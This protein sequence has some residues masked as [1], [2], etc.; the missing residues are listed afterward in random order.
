[1]TTPSTIAFQL[2]VDATWTTYAAFHDDGWTMQI[3]PD[4][5][6]GWRPNKLST[7]FQ[8]LD[9]SMDPSNVTS[10]LYGKI[11]Q[12]TPARMLIN[13]N[14]VV[15]VEASDWQPDRT[16]DHTVTPAKGKAWVDLT[17]EGLLRR[18]SKWTDE[19][20][21]A[22]LRQI[23][24]YSANGLSG[25]SPLEDDATAKTLRQVVPGV[26][27]GS[28]S[29]TVTLAGDEGPGGSDS[30]LKLGSDG[31]VTTYFRSSS[32]SGYQICFAFQ[33]SSVPASATYLPLAT[34]YDSRG[35]RWDWQVSSAGFGWVCTDTDGTVLTSLTSLL[36]SGIS[37]TAWTRV[38]M[39]VTVSAGTLTYEPAWYSQDA[40]AVYGVTQTFAAT[41][42]GQPA[43]WR[44]AGNTYTDGTAYSHVF[45][46]TDTALNLNSP[47][48]ALQSFNGFPGELPP[49]RW[50]R[51][52]AERGI[53]C[54]V[55]GNPTIGL[56]MGQQK[57]GVL[58]D[59]LTEC[60]T[61]D[62]GL[63]YD[64]PS[65]VGTSVPALTFSTRV[66][67]INRT[68][69]LALTR[70]QLTAPFK[71]RIDDVGKVNTVT[72]NNASGEKATVTLTAGRKSVQPPPAGIGEYKGG[73][74]DGVNLLD[75]VGDL[76]SRAMLELNKGTLDRPRYDTLTINLL[77][78]PGLKNTIA[79]MRPGDW[80]SVTGEEPDPIILRAISWERR[81]DA[82]QDLVTF[83]CLPAE[84]FQVA[85]IDNAAALIDSSSSTVNAGFTSTATTFVVTTYDPTEVWTR[86]AAVDLDI[87]GERIGVPT[88][89]FSAV[90]GTGP[91]LQ[92]VTG[93]VRSKNGVVKAQLAAAEVHVADQVRIF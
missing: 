64:E 48:D 5:E 93:A 82:F 1:V 42:T 59:L 28:I 84:V 89:G 65:A 91:Y 83:S 49:Y 40:S 41:A 15:Q 52:L 37:L 30:V 81:G 77:T 31:L 68:V 88:G 53:S 51:L 9:L 69:S 11:G 54:Y 10:P 50:A 75:P 79:G 19:I 21:S 7:T 22:M 55:N 12:N 29:G 90:T 67:L 25:Y 87:A 74:G 38:R 92:T 35:R 73:V 4:V 14:A 23:S 70:S 66:N 16:I 45:A 18:L 47:G 46:V 56:P 86:T 80:I 6:T 36:G 62:G 60:V 71:R 78:Y 24:S 27:A 34:W 8:N 13:G 72:A 26:Q 39:R 76:T 3:G 58:L 57:S 2:Y 85:V 43:R 32:A 63:M 20:D 44:A 61:T 17:G 33:M